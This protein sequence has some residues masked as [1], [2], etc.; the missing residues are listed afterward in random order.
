MAT[1]LFSRVLKS[2]AHNGLALIKL[3]MAVSNRQHRL[4]WPPKWQHEHSRRSVDRRVTNSLPSFTCSGRVFSSQFSRSKRIFF[5]GAAVM[6][7]GLATVRR[8]GDGN[9]AIGGIALGDS[10]ELIYSIHSSI[11]EEP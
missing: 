9:T 7:T 10:V 3:W 11:K 4:F 2:A 6:R 8:I 5:E 1:M